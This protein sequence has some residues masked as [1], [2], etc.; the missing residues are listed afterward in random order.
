[1]KAKT[2]LEHKKIVDILKSL[3]QKLDTIFLD[4]ITESI[5][6]NVTKS[7][8][9]RRAEVLCDILC[10]NT[11]EYKEK[12]YRY[13]STKS[14]KEKLLI[15]YG[16]AK[17]D[18][19]RNKLIN[20]PRRVVSRLQVKYWIDKGFS[21]EE[22]ISKIQEIQRY[23]NSKR[24]KESYNNYKYKSKLSLL[25]WESRGYSKEEAEL[26]RTPYVNKCKNDLQ[27]MIIKYGEIEG[28][29]KYSNRI[30]KYK[31]SMQKILSSKKINGSVSKESLK[32]FI[33]FYKKIRKLG[34]SRDDINFGINGS[35]EFFIKDLLFDYNTGRFYD[36]TIKSLK[37][38]IEYN[39]S[40]WHP[41]NRED[42]KNPWISYDDAKYTDQY[43]E[44]LAK[45]FGMDY[46]IVWDFDNKTDKMEMLLN[47]VKEKMD[48][49]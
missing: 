26:L 5:V 14:T 29:I 16:E 44:K 13:Y 9:Y 15:R 47:Y 45:N 33:P 38:I 28:R 42:W 10:N 27:S 4:I 48:D 8:I 18:S 31:D 37:I 24:S 6:E 23:N 2:I 21:K 46:F 34:I 7:M 41:T 20:R 43:K 30:L 1:M 17:V 40:F 39:G 3:P 25:Y 22:A 36:F 11:S 35:R 19:Y 32:F 12:F 49:K